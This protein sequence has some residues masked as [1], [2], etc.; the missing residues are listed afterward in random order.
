MHLAAD[1]IGSKIT[2][3]DLQNHRNNARCPNT[4]HE[5]KCILFRKDAGE[6][7]KTP[8][9][10]APQSDESLICSIQQCHQAVF[11][12]VTHHGSR[13]AVCP[14]RPFWQFWFFL[15]VVFVSWSRLLMET[16]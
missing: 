5:Y 4:L 7:H 1:G 6:R 12:D 9:L 2:G 3:G 10:L 15:R 8:T 16:T 14:D 11:A 13:N